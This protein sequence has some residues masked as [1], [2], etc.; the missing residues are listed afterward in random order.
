M[1][2]FYNITMGSG[3]FALSIYSLNATAGNQLILNANSNTGYQQWTWVSYPLTNGCILYNPYTNLYAA[4]RSLE[5]GAPVILFAMPANFTFS[6][7]NTWNFGAVPNGLVAVRPVAQTGLNLSA[8]G[9]SG[10]VDGA[11]IVISAWG[12]GGQNEIWKS[13]LVGNWRI[14]ELTNNTGGSVFWSDFEP[15]ATTRG[16]AGSAYT[17]I[18]EQ[19]SGFIQMTDVGA[20]AGHW[21]VLLNGSTWLYDIPGEM[22]LTINQDGSFTAAGGRSPVSG[23]LI[24]VLN[25]ITW[26]SNLETQIGPKKLRQV[27]LPGTHNSGTYGISATSGFSNEQ[28]SWINL[29]YAGYFLN[30]VLT[31]VIMST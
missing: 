24:P 22:Q 30:A 15:I 16:P 1:D 17:L 19:C 4:P 9:S 23:Q 21:G 29:G 25:P 10:G 11:P 13:T 6:Q 27:A 12:N 31:G 20:T 7:N 3:N 2:L 26:M 28:S 8:T 5:Q 14:T 18:S